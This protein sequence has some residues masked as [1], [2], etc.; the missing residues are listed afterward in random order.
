MENQAQKHI[1]VISQV[2]GHLTSPA[3]FAY[4]V[5]A[6]QNS[7][8]HSNGLPCFFKPSA[9]CH[10][11]SRCK[12]HSAWGAHPRNCNHS[13]MSLPWPQ[14]TTVAQGQT[15]GACK[16]WK[17]HINYSHV[18]GEMRSCHLNAFIHCVHSASYCYQEMSGYKDST[19]CRSQYK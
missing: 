4:F 7:S 19:K 13:L 10:S 1:F 11:P 6:E 18:L 14:E 12:G 9:M 17:H 5:R 3:I 15:A 2:R 16:R 8:G